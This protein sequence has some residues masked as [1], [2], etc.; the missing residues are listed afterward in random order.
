MNPVRAGPGRS[1]SGGTI[2]TENQVP[3][4]EKFRLSSSFVTSRNVLH[5]GSG[6]GSGRVE[7]I[8]SW[9]GTK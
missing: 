8:R 1:G 3:R 9:S 7:P 2:L 4:L 6:S 5:N